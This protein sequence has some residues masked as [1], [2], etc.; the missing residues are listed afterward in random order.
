LV[1]CSEPVGAEPSAQAGGS[2]GSTADGGAGT[3]A[4]GGAGGIQH[5]GGSCALSCSSDLTKVVDCQGATVAECENGLGCAPGGQCVDACE[6]SRASGSALGCEFFT[7]APDLWFNSWGSCYA[8]LVTNV[9][10]TPADLS[11][12]YGAQELGP[13]AYTIDV[14]PAGM[15]F[16]PL[17]GPLAPGETA[18]LF[19]ADH[20]NGK[21]SYAACPA[22]VNVGVTDHDASPHETALATAFEITTSVPTVAYSF[23]PFGYQETS[24][25]VPSAIASASL[26]LPTSSWAENYLVITPDESTTLSQYGDVYPWFS[27]VAA[28]DGTEVT[29][30]A[31]VDIP[32]GPGVAAVAAGTTHTYALDRGQVL[33]FTH[34]AGLIGSP[35]LANKPIAQFSGHGLFEGDSVHQQVLPI[36]TLGSV[37]PLVRPRDRVDGQA[38]VAR[39][40]LVGVVDGTQVTFDPARPSIELDRG[41]VFDL[42]TGET[43]IAASQGLSHPFYAFEYMLLE[44]KPGGLNV[45]DGEFLNVIPVEQALP[46]Y[47]LFLEPGYQNSHLVIIRARASAGFADVTLD[48]LG[49]IGGFSPLGTSGAYEFARVDLVEANAP[50]GAC[51]AGF[52]N[53]ESTAPFVGRAWGWSELGF[54]NGVGVSYG[55]PF[56]FSTKPINEVIVPPVP[57]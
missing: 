18:V 23:S 32:G 28:E 33:H 40:R 39:F 29:I 13:I 36:P 47:D 11:A 41:E 17:A 9:W 46:R 19:L 42:E 14:T 55:Y 49:P 7:R 6:A 45:G 44:K 57:H 53:L 30:A 16:D 26:L 35:I 20:P 56:G 34:A 31:S 2:A 54:E 51:G 48:C 21:S 43:L 1:S 38:D 3:G 8:V 27:F 10:S 12:R 4:S 25:G 37:Y 52:R 15:Q 5:D 24:P 22:G 50:V